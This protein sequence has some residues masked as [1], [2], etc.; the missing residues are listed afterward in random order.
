MENLEEGREMECF[1]NARHGRYTETKIDLD[2]KDCKI[3]CLIKDLG[4]Q[5]GS[6][7]EIKIGVLGW[8]SYDFKVHIN[9]SSS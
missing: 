5:T 1:V 8:C 9:L 6:P 7:S 4:N 2:Q 3:H